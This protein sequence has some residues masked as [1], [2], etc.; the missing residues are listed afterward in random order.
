MRALLLYIMQDVLS[1][2]SDEGGHCLPYYIIPIKWNN[3]ELCLNSIFS[4]DN[5]KWSNKNKNYSESLEKNFY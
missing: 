4:S 2:P 1:E 3:H 5:E